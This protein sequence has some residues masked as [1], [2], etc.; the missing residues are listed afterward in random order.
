MIRNPIA[1]QYTSRNQ[2]R[3]EWL[4]IH[5]Q[6]IAQ[7]PEFRNGSPSSMPVQKDSRGPPA[8]PIVNG[9]SIVSGYQME[10][11]Y[12]KFYDIVSSSSQTTVYIDHYMLSNKIHSAMVLWC[13]HHNVPI[14]NLEKRFKK[15]ITPEIDKHLSLSGNRLKNSTIQALKK[16]FPGVIWH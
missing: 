1:F 6:I 12:G 13:K 15:W 5:R 10:G 7:F 2:H 11:L 14:H 9:H 8:W 3:R 16:H 4:S